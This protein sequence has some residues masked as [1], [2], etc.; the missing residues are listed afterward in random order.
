MHA[1]FFLVAVLPLYLYLILK[2]ISGT[3]S[4]TGLEL[5]SGKLD[6]SLS[7]PSKLFFIF[8]WLYIVEIACSRDVLQTEI[9]KLRRKR[10]AAG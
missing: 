9:R 10:A 4:L 2:W 6:F 5:L 8:F 1:T 7:D 3:I